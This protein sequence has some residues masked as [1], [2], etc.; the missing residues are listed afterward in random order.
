MD[1]S[2]A[3]DSMQRGLLLDK[4]HSYGLSKD[5]CNFVI[6]SNESRYK[7]FLAT[8]QLQIGEYPRAQF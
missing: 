1:L 4:L 2:K 5:A 7:L 6:D 8:G 3:F